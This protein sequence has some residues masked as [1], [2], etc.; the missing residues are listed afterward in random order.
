MKHPIIRM[1]LFI[2]EAYIVVLMILRGVALFTGQPEPS[3][4]TLTISHFT[5][6]TILLLPLILGGEVILVGGSA[7]LGAVTTFIQRES[8]L[9]RS[10]VAGLIIAGYQIVEALVF[11]QFSWSEAIYL[12]SG[13]MIFGLAGYLRMTEYR[14][15]TMKREGGHFYIGRVLQKSPLHV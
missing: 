14:G 3:W 12:V 1:A 15:W 6:A 2:L 7:L 10:M 5:V 9:R 13:L 4:N 11:L 8:A